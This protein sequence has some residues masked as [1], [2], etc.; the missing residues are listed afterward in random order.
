MS[1]CILCN[2]KG[3][4]VFSLT[5]SIEVHRYYQRFA[6]FTLTFDPLLANVHHSAVSTIPRPHSSVVSSLLYFS[7]LP[8]VHSVLQ[9]LEVW[10]RTEVCV[11][12]FSQA[13]RPLRVDPMVSLGEDL[14]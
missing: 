9:Q 7:F 3:I 14:Q 5:I 12:K 8:I 4:S 1:L 6:M 11:Y 10:C 13:A 2:K